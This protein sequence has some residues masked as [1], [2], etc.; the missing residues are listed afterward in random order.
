MEGGHGE[1]IAKRSQSAYLVCHEMRRNV[2]GFFCLFSFGLFGLVW[3]TKICMK[4][5]EF[6]HCSCRFVL[7]GQIPLYK[8]ISSRKS[9]VLYHKF[10]YSY[11]FLRQ[12]AENCSNYHFVQCM[13]NASP[14]NQAAWY[15]IPLTSL[16]VCGLAELCWYNSN[17]QFATVYRPWA[18][19]FSVDDTPEK[20]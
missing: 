5:S 16:Q 17:F 18:D 2:W 3:S 4:L 11:I 20:S 6:I 8:L 1:I 19:V 13:V 7:M 10:C 15:S 14:A 9:E 12:I